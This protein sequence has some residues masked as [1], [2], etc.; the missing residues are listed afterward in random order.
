MKP[1]KPIPK[2]SAKRKAAIA[3]GWK[4]KPGKPLKR[5]ALKKKRKAT[6]EL[7]FFL[8]LYEQHKDS[9]V[10]QISGADLVPPDFDDDGKLT[11]GRVF[12]SQFSHILP[13]GTYP[14]LRK[15]PG[16][17]VFKTV[18]EHRLWEQEKWTLVDLPHW[19]W[20]FAKEEEMKRGLYGA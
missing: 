15:E 13:K 14:E 17:I 18:E 3:S 7:A 1:R 2:V 6:G 8:G 20:V 5:T 10:S 19:Q 12:V 9:W 4:P 11:N 16:N